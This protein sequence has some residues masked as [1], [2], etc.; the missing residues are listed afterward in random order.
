MKFFNPSFATA[1]VS[2]SYPCWCRLLY[3][4]KLPSAANLK[5]CLIL[6]LIECVFNKHL[7]FCDFRDFVANTEAVPHSSV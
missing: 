7:L 4:P 3:A 2:L 1:F 6:E 5:I